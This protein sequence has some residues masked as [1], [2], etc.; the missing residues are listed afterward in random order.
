MDF[1]TAENRY[2]IDSL[3]KRLKEPLPGDS[4]RMQLATLVNGINNRHIAPTANVRQSAVL[5]LLWERN[6]KL[7][8]VFTLRSQTLL[9]HRGQISFPGGN[10][11]NNE[12]PEQAAL[13]ETREEIG[14]PKYQIELLGRLSPLYVLPSNSNIIPVVGLAK[15]YLDFTVNQ[16]EV[17]E[18]FSR[19]VEFFQ[20]S[21][22]RRKNIEIDGN[23]LDMPYWDMYP[24]TRLWGATAIIL[25]EFMA[26]YWKSV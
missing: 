24:Y 21:S 25:A 14:I 19:P 8:I 17:E 2:I 9:H 12:T 3:K 26:L 7:Q 20:F 11:E 15:Q 22:V 13:R 16:D 23:K 4:M 1:L 6:E 18:V 10:I 5:L